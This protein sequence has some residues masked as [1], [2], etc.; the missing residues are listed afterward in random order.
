GAGKERKG[1]NDNTSNPQDIPNKPLARTNTDFKETVD[2]AE[3]DK[4]HVATDGVERS[5]SGKST[6][7]IDATSVSLSNQ[8]ARVRPRRISMP[9]ISSTRRASS[10]PLS[11]NYDDGEDDGRRHS[12][13]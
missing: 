3:D 4:V 1:G 11:P 13:S 10:V 9:A 12:F 2:R 7:D 6:I 5:M 8:S